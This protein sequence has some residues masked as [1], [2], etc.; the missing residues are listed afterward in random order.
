MLLRN[1]PL[2]FV[3]CKYFCVYYMF[4]F[5]FTTQFALPVLISI[6]TWH[7]LSILILTYLKYRACSLYKSEAIYAHCID[8][9]QTTKLLSNADFKVRPIYIK[10]QSSIF[11]YSLNYKQSLIVDL[12]N[13]YMITKK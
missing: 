3:W 1:S 12:N 13:V 4:K 11:S 5:I 6:V 10:F 8:K 7:F 9:N 2:I